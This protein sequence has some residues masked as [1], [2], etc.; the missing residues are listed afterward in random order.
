MSFEKNLEL[1]SYTKCISINFSHKDM[2]GIG[3][4]EDILIV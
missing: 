1:Y 4:F 3:C 2:G